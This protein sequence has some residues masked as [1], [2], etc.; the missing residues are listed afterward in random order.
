MFSHLSG[1]LGALVGVMWVSVDLETVLDGLSKREV[2]GSSVISIGV[3]WLACVVA[4]FVD[5]V[6][7]VYV[8]GFIAAS[9]ISLEKL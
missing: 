3:M 1:K 2:L 5:R 4:V 8:A 7:S 9:V 6:V